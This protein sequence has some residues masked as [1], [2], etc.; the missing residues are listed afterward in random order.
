MTPDDLARLVDD[1]Q[2][3]RRGGLIL[4]DRLTVGGES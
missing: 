3:G 4:A 2:R 1:E